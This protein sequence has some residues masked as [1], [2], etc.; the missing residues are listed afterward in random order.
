MRQQNLE[1][2][3]EAHG[4]V[5]LAFRLSAGGWAFEGLY[6]PLFDFRSLTRLEVRFVVDSATNPAL[7]EG[8]TLGEAALWVTG[9]DTKT[10]DDGSTSVIRPTPEGLVVLRQ[11]PQLLVIGR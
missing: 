8:F 3:R 6:Q 5:R 2:V 9:Y 11:E 7:I 4:R 1:I 10:F